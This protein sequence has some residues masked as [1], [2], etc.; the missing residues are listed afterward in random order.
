MIEQI[1]PIKGLLEGLIAVVGVILGIY[2]VG[3]NEYLHILEQTIGS[4]IGMPLVTV[5]LVEGFFQFEATAF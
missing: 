4:P 2:T 5:Y 3:N 1:A